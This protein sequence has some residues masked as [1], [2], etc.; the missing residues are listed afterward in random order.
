MLLI[1]YLQIIYMFIIIYIIF[2][3]LS[4]NVNKQ[5]IM[6]SIYEFINIY[7]IRTMNKKQTL[8]TLLTVPV[9]AFNNLY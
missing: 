5:E 6:K 7:L 8:S 2:K 3:I 1:I 4:F 9:H